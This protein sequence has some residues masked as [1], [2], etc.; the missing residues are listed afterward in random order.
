MRLIGWN[1]TICNIL[2]FIIKKMVQM[3]WKE[4][5]RRLHSHLPSMNFLK[6][7]EMLQMVKM[8]FQLQI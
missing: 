3:T 1:S 6:E 4:R 5:L 7:T 8:E 2:Q